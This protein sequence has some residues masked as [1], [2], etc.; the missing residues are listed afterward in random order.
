[1]VYNKLISNTN[2]VPKFQIL[3]SFVVLNKASFVKY[4]G[5]NF[6]LLNQFEIIWNILINIIKIVVV[7]F[8]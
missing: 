1:M 5:S 3:L 4:R 2:K 6:I 8:F 7:H